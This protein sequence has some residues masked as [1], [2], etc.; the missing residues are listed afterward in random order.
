MRLEV[1]KRDRTLF[2]EFAGEI[3]LRETERIRQ[4]VGHYLTADRVDHLVFDFSGVGFIDSSGL[5]CILSCYRTMRE[6]GGRVSIVGASP[7]VEK[8]LL[9]SGIPKIIPLYRD[10]AEFSKGSEQAQE[11]S[12]VF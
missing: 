7:A 2:A 1:K 5:G 10:I 8:V 12:R 11:R 3:D 4:E 9:F 6:T